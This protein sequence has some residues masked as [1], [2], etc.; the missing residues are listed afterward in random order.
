[1]T[2]FGLRLLPTALALAAIVLTAFA[3]AGARPALAGDDSGGLLMRDTVQLS[4]E[5]GNWF[6]SEATGTPV[7]VIGSA[8]ASTSTAATTRTRATRPRS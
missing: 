7:T 5:P 3:G 1:M 8:A 4:D 6:R 2:V